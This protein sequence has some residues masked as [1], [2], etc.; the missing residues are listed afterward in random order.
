MVDIQNASLAGGV[1]VGSSADLVI[2][3]WAAALI[4]SLAAILSVFGY[5]KIQPLLERTI[6]L[7]DTCG[8][9]NLHG[10]PGLMGALGGVIAAAVADD[11][12]YP[13]SIGGVATVWPARGKPLNRTAGEQALN[14]FYTML[15][16]CFL[17]II[18]GLISGFITRMISQ[19]DPVDLEFSDQ[20]YWQEGEKE[21]GKGSDDAPKKTVLS[22]H[23]PG[24][25]DENGKEHS[26]EMEGATG[27]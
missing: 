7:Y 6:G 1:A 19:F 22:A 10:M 9:H 11:K 20:E 5:T 18:G 4:G 14:Q 21:V 13:K 17:A 12:V 8:I 25:E 23:I 3:P 16:S 24:D 27:A 26:V 15:V 2:Q